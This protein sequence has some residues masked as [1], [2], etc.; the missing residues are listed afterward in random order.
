MHVEQENLIGFVLGV[1]ALIGICLAFVLPIGNELRK[2][3]H[4]ETIRKVGTIIP[5]SSTFGG[6]FGAWVAVDE[7]LGVMGSALAGVNIGAIFA[8][9][10]TIVTTLCFGATVLV[11]YWIRLDRNWVSMAVCSSLI[12]PFV[13][14]VFWNAIFP[15]G[16]S[17]L[18]AIIIQ[19][20]SA[21]GCVIAI[22]WVRSVPPSEIG[23]QESS[24]RPRS[25]NP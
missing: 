6:L 9:V 20:S 25:K 13:L 24:H 3:R 11:A 21:C 23:V 14:R 7:G 5:L 22:Y 1:T 16:I 12:A 18:D 8:I 4:G 2:L 19:G 15:G 17:W 10:L